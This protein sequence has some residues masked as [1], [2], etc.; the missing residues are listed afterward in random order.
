MEQK[1]DIWRERCPLTIA[2]VLAP[3]AATSGART[4]PPRVTPRGL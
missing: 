1:A 3:L 2:I 4:L